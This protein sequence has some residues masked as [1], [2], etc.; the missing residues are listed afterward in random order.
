MSQRLLRCVRWRTIQS[1]YPLN[2]IRLK[3]IAPICRSMSH[4]I[5]FIIV[6]NTSFARVLSTRICEGNRSRCY[7]LLPPGPLLFMGGER[8]DTI[9]VDTRYP[10]S[11][12][13]FP[14][15]FIGYRVSGA[16]SAV[17]ACCVEAQHA[18]PLTGS[19][20]HRVAPLPAPARHFH[21]DGSPGM[22]DKADSHR[23]QTPSQPG[24]SLG[25]GML[26]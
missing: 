24:D 11:G 6:N 21:A 22:S 19:R 20:A 16:S 9:I 10:V 12:I 5:F 15:S 23:Q 14:V 1:H 3:K 7:W 2:S 26:V 25:G 4:W 8:L 13:R 18:E 17:I